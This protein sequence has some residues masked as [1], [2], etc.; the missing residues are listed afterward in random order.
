MDGGR[1]CF[2]RMNLEH[3][4]CVQLTALKTEVF[5]PPLP[6]QCFQFLAFLPQLRPSG[7]F[8]VCFPSVTACFDDITPSESQPPG[9]PWHLPVPVNLLS[10]NFSIFSRHSLWGKFRPPVYCCSWIFVFNWCRWKPK[11]KLW[12]LGRSVKASGATI[13]GIWVYWSATAR[14]GAATSAALSIVSAAVAFVFDPV[15][16]CV[17]DA[18][19][20]PRDVKVWVFGYG[21]IVNL[22]CRSKSWMLFPPGDSGGDSSPLALSIAALMSRGI[23][24]D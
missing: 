2:V 23:R 18:Y 8:C 17:S 6:L 24:T 14:R 10:T 20:R 1:D 4:E 19:H 22:M 15:S 5:C 9:S 3:K 7:K 16:A 12:G 21:D 11:I 13:C